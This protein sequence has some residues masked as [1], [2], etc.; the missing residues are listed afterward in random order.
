MREGRGYHKLFITLRIFVVKLIL[1]QDLPTDEMLQKMR[2]ERSG[3]AKTVPTG[4]GDSLDPSSSQDVPD[5][6]SSLPPCQTTPSTLKKTVHL[7]SPEVLTNWY[8]KRKKVE[9][10]YS[11]GPRRNSVSN[12]FFHP[13]KKQSSPLVEL[14][15]SDKM[16]K[17]MLNLEDLYAGDSST[18]SGK[19]VQRSESAKLSSE[20]NRWRGKGIQRS[21]SARLITMR[22]SPLQQRQN[23]HPSL[24]HQQSYSSSSS[25]LADRSS[26]ESPSKLT[27]CSLSN[28]DPFFGDNP[29]NSD[30]DLEAEADPPDW[31]HSLTVEELTQLSAKELKRQDVINELFHTEKS[32]VRNLKVLESVFRQPL[33]EKGRMSKELSNKLFAN[34]DEVLALHQKYNTSMKNRVKN[35]F[36]VGDIGDILTE[37]FLDGN[38]DKLVQVVGEF[39]K[40]QN[41]TIE[42]LK[43]TRSR[44][45][46]LELFLSELERKPACRR[47]QLQSMLPMEHQ[48]L[49]KYPLLLEQIAKFSDT[50]NYNTEH[51]IVMSA[52]EKTKDILDS[53][54]RLVARQQN[55][56]RLSEI[57]LNID[58]S[59]LD[60]LGSDNPI[61][62]EYKNLDLTKHVLVYDGLL[63][64]K[65]GDTKRLK[66]L[67]VVLLEDCMMLLQ[68]Q[69]EKYLLKFHNNQSQGGESRR[70]FHSPIIKFSTMLVRPV[71]TDKRAFYLLNTTE[72]GPQIYELLAGSTS[73]RTRWIKHITEVS[74]AYKSRDGVPKTKSEPEQLGSSLE[75]KEKQ[76]LRSQSFRDPGGSPRMSRADRQN[77]SPP[78]CPLTSPDSSESKLEPSSPDSGTSTPSAPKKRLQRVEILKIVDSE[79]M[80]EP[81]QVR[82]NQTT[83]LVADP[84]ITPFELL[85]QKA[86]IPLLKYIKKSYWRDHLYTCPC[87]S[88]SL[89]SYS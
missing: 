53:I 69:G 81:S 85:R 72:C 71:A 39:I 45:A 67:H 86:G 20:R 82:V 10:L 15:N 6:L 5:G 9:S 78:E 35:G 61:Y 70:A 64:L 12:L 19:G 37:M 43:R 44:D 4:L 52:M 54:D 16:R 11:L 58:T 80:I 65:L 63:T 87:P 31:R 18:G 68:K 73:E 42:E 89:P 27:T 83:V 1:F 40:N 26:L 57:Q 38:G 84:V 50:P 32:H 33:V 59:G 88:F 23:S 17:S 34:L 2:K 24:V 29:N 77:S 28:N 13:D 47:L 7:L 48:R 76:D 75:R 51:D 55:K 66:Q 14:K 56:E 21:E 62:K 79:P 36:P 60:K 46:K 74:N 22:Q 30:S 8:E 25:S 41:F 49:V 3:R